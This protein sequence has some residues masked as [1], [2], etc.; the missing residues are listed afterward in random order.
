MN[1]LANGLKLD[2]I[3]SKTEPINEFPE[4]DLLQKVKENITQ[5][6]FYIVYMTYTVFCGRYENN[7][8]NCPPDKT[9]EPE[10]VLKLRVFNKDEEIHIW[11]EQP[12]KLKGRYRQD[13][14]DG[15]NTEF[16]EANQV[17]FGTRADNY[18]PPGPQGG[19]EESYSKQ[20][21][22]PPLGDL[23]GK[24]YSKLTEDRGTEVILPFSKDKLQV[25][26]KQNRIAIK[27]R[28]YIGYTNEGL[29]AGYIDCRFVRFVKMNGSNQEEIL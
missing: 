16:I 10:L 12:G 9:I 6:S 5:D 28:N 8:F 3:I 13:G 26:D 7:K 2:N 17:L 23:G 20:E 24:D 19:S 15:K 4:K 25:D 27:T 29:Q 21:E 11:R 1:K 22:S 18:S 14:S